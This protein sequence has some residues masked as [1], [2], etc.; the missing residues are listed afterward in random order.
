MGCRR[1]AFGLVGSMA[2][3]TSDP[4]RDPG[5]ETKSTCL[6]DSAA[7]KALT[8]LSAEALSAAVHA[9]EVSCREVTRAYLE[10]IHRLNPS[11][12]CINNLRPD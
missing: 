10:R 2:E 11:Y 6:V 12:V 8:E 4:I 3:L 9:R 1:A 5:I 7:T